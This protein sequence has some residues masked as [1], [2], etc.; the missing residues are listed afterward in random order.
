MELFTEPAASQAEF[1]DCYAAGKGLNKAPLKALG[2]E[3]PLFP[4]VKVVGHI[5][6]PIHC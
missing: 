2:L 5:E 6:V 4:T 1:G 3:S